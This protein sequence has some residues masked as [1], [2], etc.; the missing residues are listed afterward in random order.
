GGAG[1][2]GGPSGGRS[3]GPRPARKDLP[4]FETLALAAL[5][6]WA[7]AEPQPKALVASVQSLRRRAGEA[8]AL[9]DRPE[10]FAR[11]VRRL[12]GEGVQSLRPS[13]NLILASRLS[14]TSVALDGKALVER[15]DLVP[16]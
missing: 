10:L 12:V 14:S 3:P 5:G 16:A 1:A 2:A 9:G 4:K 11:A 8:G 7:G 15:Q 13:D 6:L